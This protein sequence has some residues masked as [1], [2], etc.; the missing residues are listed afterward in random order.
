MDKLLKNTEI[1]TD[2]Q[3]E[4]GSATILRRLAVEHKPLNI[5]SETRIVSPMGLLWFCGVT[6]RF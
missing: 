6:D 1:Q 5:M 4:I 3:S 2:W